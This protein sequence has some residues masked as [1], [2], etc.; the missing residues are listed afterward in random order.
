MATACD[1]IRLK[2]PLAHSALISARV[3]DLKSIDT[4]SFRNVLFFVERFPALLP[5]E[6][7]ESNDEALNFLEMEFV[8]LQA[9]VIPPDVLH[10]ERADAQWNAISQL[11]GADGLLKFGRISVVMLG[12]LSIPHSNAECE[13]Q[14][15]IVKK[16]RTQFRESMS[17]TTLGH[18]LLAKCRS[19]EPC[20]A[21]QYSK[22]FLKRAASATSKI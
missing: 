13:R 4:M 15:S 8:K 17:D 2:F 16:N 3:A 5:L 10:E 18:I 9:F 7:Q 14:F 11:R 20:Y 21:R 22:D 12:I 6:Q 19:G 1:Y